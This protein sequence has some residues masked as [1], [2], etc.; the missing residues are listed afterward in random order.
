MNHDDT[1]KALEWAIKNFAVAVNQASE[2]E[3]KILS[4]AFDEGVMSNF[5]P[6]QWPFAKLKL[7][8]QDIFSENTPWELSDEQKHE[9]ARVQ[10]TE[11]GWTL[12]EWNQT[13]AQVELTGVYARPGNGPMPYVRDPRDRPLARYG[14]EPDALEVLVKLHDTHGVPLSQQAIVAAILGA[15]HP[16]TDGRHARAYA[17]SFQA[18]LVLREASNGNLRAILGVLVTEQEKITHASNREAQALAARSPKDTP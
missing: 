2:G 7:A 15:G 3:I 10:I 4:A 5:H 6:G 1:V 17:D 8:L 11:A 16:V 12:G 13:A 9:R 14:V 18:L